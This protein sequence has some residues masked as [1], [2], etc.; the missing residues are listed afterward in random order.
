MVNWITKVNILWN[1]FDYTQLH[2]MINSDSARDNVI[3]NWV[4]W[5]GSTPDN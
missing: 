2:L 1:F 4:L 3:I 5:E